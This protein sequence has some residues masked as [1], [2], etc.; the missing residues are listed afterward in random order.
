MSGGIVAARLQRC[1]AL[2]STQSILSFSLF[3]LL[4]ETRSRLSRLKRYPFLS[5]AAVL[6]RA[7]TPWLRNGRLPMLPVQLSDSLASEPRVSQSSRGLNH[8]S[9]RELLSWS[10]RGSR[11][12][13]LALAYVIHLFSIGINEAVPGWLDGLRRPTSA[14]DE[15]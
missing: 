6:C 3:L 11:N 9:R 7:T 12:E 1:R 4:L 13:G 10:V 14:V 8:A 2:F 5:P 15:Q